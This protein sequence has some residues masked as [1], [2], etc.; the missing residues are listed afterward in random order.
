M[1]IVVCLTML[2]GL[3][4]FL[5]VRLQPLWL[6]E[7]SSDQEHGSARAGISRHL[8]VAVLLLLIGLWNT[9]WYGAQHFELF[10]GKT[11]VVSGVIMVLVA[12]ILAAEVAP[13]NSGSLASVYRFLK[14][15]RQALVVG[16]LAGFLLY[17]ITLV[18]LNLGYPII[19]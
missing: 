17:A 4:M 9:F 11:A 15:L 16:L 19:Q 5:P 13:Q 18:Q 14:P 12:I 7:K 3:L 1:G 6:K 10:W 2:A 8:I